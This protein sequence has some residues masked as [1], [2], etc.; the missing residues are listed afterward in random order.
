M[1]K[2]YRGLKKLREPNKFM[3]WM[4]TIAANHVIKVH[5]KYRSRNETTFH[6]YC[7][8]TGI[9]EEDGENPGAERVSDERY[10]V[11]RQ[12]VLRELRRV[13]VFIINKLPIKMRSMN[14]II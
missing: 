14:Y 11:E 1:I 8:R 12:V 4:F 10:D 6:E 7:Q 2:V 5:G 13:L 3:T 9:R